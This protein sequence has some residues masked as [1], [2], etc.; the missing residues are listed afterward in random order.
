MWPLLKEY[1]ALAQHECWG[2]RL[3]EGKTNSMH[4]AVLR[5]ADETVVYGWIEWPSKEVRDRAWEA[6]NKDARM[7]TMDMPFDGSR[8][9]FGG[10]ERLFSGER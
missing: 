6:M 9:L 8:M 10:F 5:K 7:A 3:P 4:T 2:D 1:G